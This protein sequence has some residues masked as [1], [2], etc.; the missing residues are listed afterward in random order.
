MSA[1]DQVLPLHEAA[2]HTVPDAQ[3]SHAPALQTPVVRHV[4]ESALGHS[5]SGS[6]LSVTLPQVP[7]ASPVLAEVQALQAPVQAPLQQTPSAQKP[8]AQSLPAR[9]ASPCAQ[10]AAQK[11]PQSTSVSLPFFTPLVQPQ[12]PLMQVSP[13]PHVPHCR[14][15]P[16]PSLWAPQDLPLTQ[17]FGVQHWPALVQIWGD[18]H[19]PQLST[20]PQPLDCVPQFLPAAAQVVGVQQFPLA[21]HTSPF[22]PQDVPA[23][24][25]VLLGFVPMHSSVV[26]GLESTGTS[27][28]SAW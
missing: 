23:G 9:H 27:L 16:Q 4:A 12:V 10:F 24:R 11:P 5:A 26:Q 3:Y 1:G 28:G 20:V 2:P 22:E 19:V 8:L 13:A 21:V 7:V 18:V 15:P 17:V 14:L 6:L 25:F